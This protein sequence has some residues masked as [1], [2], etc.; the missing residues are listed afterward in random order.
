MMNTNEL[1]MNEAKFN[2][3]P[4]V[5]RLLRQSGADINYRDEYGWSLLVVAVAYIRNSGTKEIITELLHLGADVNIILPQG[6]TLLMEAKTAEIVR[7]LLGA[8]AN[9]DVRNEFGDSVLDWYLRKDRLDAARML[10]QLTTQPCIPQNVARC[11]LNERRYEHFEIGMGTILSTKDKES[12]D[13]CYSSNR[14]RRA[15][16]LLRRYCPW[17]NGRRQGS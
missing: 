15:N 4:E 11:Y 6:Q 12:F 2:N 14:D 17:L 10:R 7:M 13:K 1:M 9:P 3:W 16:E 5:F 8:G